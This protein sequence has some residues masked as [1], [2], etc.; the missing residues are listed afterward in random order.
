MHRFLAWPAAIAA[1]VAAVQ[2][3][4]SP[5]VSR[6]DLSPG[7]HL[8]FREQLTR[9]ITTDGGESVSRFE[10]ENHVLV[11]E[12]TRGNYVVA[13]QRNRTTASVVRAR[14]GRRDVRAERQARLETSLQQEPARFADA[15]W[16]TPSGQ[17]LLPTSVV[18]ETAS[19]LLP[20][21]HE[22]L[23]LPAQTVRPGAA[24][25]A[26]GVLPMRM[27]AS[28]CPPQEGADCVSIAG[29]SDV[30][31]VQALFAPAEG[32][33]RTLTASGEYSVV[34]G[35]RVREEIVFTFAGR[36]RQETPE[37]WLGSP[38][39]RQAVL[40]GWLIASRVPVAPARIH[41]LI[42]AGDV[43]T[44]K[45]VL[46][47]LWRHRL[48]APPAETLRP[49]DAS[50]SGRVKLLAAMFAAPA[51]PSA[52]LSS[53]NR[54][55]I[56]PLS[57]GCRQEWTAA[58]ARRTLPGQPPGAG[59]RG[60][61][62]DGFSGWPY[63]VMVPAEYRGDQAYPL[64]VYLGGGPGRAVPTAQQVAPAFVDSG[65]LVLFPQADGMW[66]T[67]GSTRML[68]A[69]LDEVQQAF[70]VDAERVFI[71]GLSNGGTGTLHFATRWPHRFAAAAPSMAAELGNG[72][73][74]TARPSS[75]GP[76]PILLMHGSSDPVIQVDEAR[77][78]KARIAKESPTTP[79]EFVV[80]EGRGHDI[81]PG[82]DGGRTLAFFE[83]KRRAAP[84]RRVTL[85]S[86]GPLP[87]RNWW[88][89]LVE[90]DGS[91]ARVTASL[92]TPGEVTIEATH[93]R[94]LRLLLAPGLVPASRPLRVTVNGRVVFDGLPPSD[95]DSY[96]AAASRL[97]DANLAPTAVI[98]ITVAR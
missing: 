20:M 60:M 73:A 18:R 16:L 55:S 24:W 95:C 87:A 7:D 76:M 59:L 26:A 78:N 80:L 91:N 98:D 37:Q 58:T 42:D 67:D 43:E 68:D 85:E 32:V 19:E 81:W 83:G 3:S 31:A 30:A 65:Y 61:T 44:S 57:V 4:P 82:T 96:L 1:L 72:V 27:T 40:Q 92:D 86:N 6:Y 36:Q 38:D 23:P 93:A 56:D 22:F 11:V 79:L 90:R 48:A 64:V 13:V 69:L 53:P 62:A 29:R 28:A 66:W 94:R 46:S 9:T 52:D 45:R 15:S 2:Q 17:M 84:P 34:G 75:L 71:A 89:E 51:A 21:F 25:D 77:R 49:L 74:S 70:N 39:T 8:L 63:V 97:H 33:V 14:E 10:W 41:A 50:P 12:S 47:V 54:Q 88:L 5:A 35:R